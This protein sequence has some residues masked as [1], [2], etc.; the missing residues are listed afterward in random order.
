MLIQSQ[1][2]AD[3]EETVGTVLCPWRQ[4][5]WSKN[6]GKFK[7]MKTFVLSTPTYVIWPPTD[8][9]VKSRVR[10]SWVVE[11]SSPLKDILIMCAYDEE[12]RIG[13][14]DIDM[15]FNPYISNGATY[16]WRKTR[17]GK[18]GGYGLDWDKNDPFGDDWSC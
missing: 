9:R 14:R 11:V 7:R 13:G 10:K 8:E 6:L 17:K 16:G 1:S 15:P 5:N 3:V 4:P 2:M 18:W 12:K